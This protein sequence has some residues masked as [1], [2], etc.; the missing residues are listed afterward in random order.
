MIILLPVS[1]ILSRKLRGRRIA[2]R[3]ARQKAH[4][5]IR[6]VSLIV[7]GVAVQGCYCPLGAFQYLFLPGGLAFL[8]I[9]GVIILLLPVIQAMFCGR[10]FCAW[11]C[12]MGGL[13]EFLYRIHVP[14]RF[15]PSGKLH[16]ILLWLKYV[17]LVGL[18]AWLVFGASPKAGQWEALFCRYDPFRTVFSLFV[19]GS[20]ILAGIMMVLSMFIRRFFCRYLCFY[21]ALLSIFNRA[22]LMRRFKRR[23]PAPGEEAEVDSDEEF[24]R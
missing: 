20:L 12:P 21:G 22:H 3:M 5:V 16:R 2:E 10:V 17:I 6:A 4:T 15:S 18:V 8:G 1:R 24:D 19:S 14:G 11:V 9:L 13:Q 23:E 7:L